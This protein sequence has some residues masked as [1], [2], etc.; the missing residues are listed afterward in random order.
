MMDLLNG[1]TMGNRQ[2]NRKWETAVSVV[3]QT[4]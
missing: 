4:S 3:V 2:R 1:V